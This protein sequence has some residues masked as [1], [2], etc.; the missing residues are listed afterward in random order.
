MQLASPHKKFISA[1]T[2]GVGATCHAC[3]HCPWMQMNNLK[4]LAE[5][6]EKE[7][8]EIVIDEEI[9]KRALIPLERMLNFKK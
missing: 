5:V 1:P 4:N 6:L 3:A 7:N 8:N 9:R 2:G